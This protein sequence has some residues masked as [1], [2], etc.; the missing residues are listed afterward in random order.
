MR[1]IRNFTNFSLNEAEVSQPDIIFDWVP[2][3][4]QINNPKNSS[5]PSNVSFMELIEMAPTTGPDI[6]SLGLYMAHKKL[7]AGNFMRIITNKMNPLTLDIAI[8][9]KEFKKTSENKDIPAEGLDLS[10]YITGT[11]VMNRFRF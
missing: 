6:S 8:F 9:D 7:S 10:A 11:N 4:D 3:D 2:F 1:H 5:V